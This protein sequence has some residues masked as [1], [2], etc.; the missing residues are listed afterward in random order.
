MIR[1]GKTYQLHGY[2]Q[3]SRGLGMITM[4]ESLTAFEL[5]LDIGCRRVQ[6]YL[7]ARPMPPAAFENLMAER[8]RLIN[9]GHASSTELS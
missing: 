2:L 6:G 4:G 3:T 1:E 5:L 7:F 8:E 9:G